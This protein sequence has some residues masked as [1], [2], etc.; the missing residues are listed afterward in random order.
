MFGLGTWELALIA[1]LILVVFGHRWLPAIGRSL[2]LLTKELRDN[3]AE[4]GE[5]PPGS[6][7]RAPIDLTDLT[8]IKSPTGKLK[9][10]GKIFGIK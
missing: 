4:T 10:L 5:T 9:L 8:A 2:G 1:L 7:K 6:T 3:G